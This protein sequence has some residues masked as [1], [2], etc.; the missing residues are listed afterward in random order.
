MKNKIFR[1]IAI[2]GVVIVIGSLGDSDLEKIGFTT[3]IIR[4]LI[5][6]ILTGVGFIG[7]KLGGCFNE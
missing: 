2:I 3:L 1:L 4:S 7:L 6:S 5:G